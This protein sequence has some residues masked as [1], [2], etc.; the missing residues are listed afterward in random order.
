M[1]KS[2]E[3]LA[4]NF[5]VTGNYGDKRQGYIHRG[6]DFGSP[7]GTRTKYRY[8]GKITKHGTNPPGE[9]LGNYTIVE[10]DY[11]NV[12]G[13]YAHLRRFRGKVGARVKRGQLGDE[14]GATGGVTGPH[15]HYAESIKG[16]TRWLNPDKD[17]IHTMANWVPRASFDRDKKILNDRI[18]K[19]DKSISQLRE[20]K[21]ILKKRISKLEAVVTREVNKRDKLDDRILRLEQTLKSNTTA[22]KLQLE[23]ANKLLIEANEALKKCQ[24]APEE[25]PKKEKANEK[26]SSWA[27][28]TDFFNDLRS[29]KFWGK[30]VK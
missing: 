2:S 26:S 12:Q 23:G 13:W 16:T 4:G 3:V 24:K 27:I 22:A 30:G 19:R 28:L 15:L 10:Y 9:D 21:R 25:P 6:K 5:P 14:T 18:S 1:L 7:S 17:N 29:G 20:D 8:N 11:S